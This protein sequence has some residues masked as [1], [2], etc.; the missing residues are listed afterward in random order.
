MRLAF[1]ELPRDALHEK[2]QDVPQWSLRG[3]WF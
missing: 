1:G 3:V 2:L